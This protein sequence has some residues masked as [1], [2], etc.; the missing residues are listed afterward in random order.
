MCMKIFS[1][2]IY[3]Y[4]RTRGYENDQFGDYGSGGIMRW[5]TIHF[6]LLVYFK[7]DKCYICLIIA[8]VLCTRYVS[9]GM[10]FPSAQMYLG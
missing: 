7:Y 8:A 10:D 3:R 6:F 1:Y 4:T 9:F 2:H 5:K